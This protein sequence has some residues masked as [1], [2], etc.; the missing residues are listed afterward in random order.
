MRDAA[1]F[2]HTWHWIKRPVGP[3]P[4]F[5]P[6]PRKGQACR[7]VARGSLNSIL[8]EFHDGWRVVTSRYAVR[9]TSPKRQMELL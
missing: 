3:P 2:D 4:D 1:A 6:M 8:V 5:A 9:L 7:V